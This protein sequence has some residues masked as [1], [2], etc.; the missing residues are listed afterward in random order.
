MAFSLTKYLKQTFA[1]AGPEDDHGGLIARV[2]ASAPEIEALSDEALRAAA[3]SLRDRV[4]GGMPADELMVEAFRLAREGSRRLL[5]L[6]PFDVQMDGAV[7][8]YQGHVVEMAT[9]EGKTLAAVFPAIVQALDGQG[10]HI[11]TVNDYLAGRDA[12]WMAPLYEL[13][14]LTVASI[15][16]RMTKEE[17]RLAYDADVTYVTANEAGF[18]YLRDPQ[19][20]AVEDVVHYPF[21]FAIVDEVDSILIDE[22]R[23]PLVIAG[24]VSGSSRYARSVAG[25]V[26]QLREGADY[27][28]DE[29]RRSVALTDAGI[30]RSE[31]LLG[32]ANL[33]SEEAG[34]LLAALSVALHAEALLHRDDDYVVKDSKI[35]LVDEFK[36][37]VADRRRWPDG[38]HTALE[39]KE[40]LPLTSEGKILGS[41]TIRGLMA[42]YPKLA[43]MTGTAQSEAQEL[44][45][46]YNLRVVVVDPN[47]PSIRIDQPDVVFTNQEA[48]WQAVGRRI[49]QLHTIG[50]PVLV[51]TRSVEESEQLAARLA[52]EGV[53]C[54]VLNAR[55]D[56]LEAGIIANAGALGAVTISTNM[57]GRG[58]DI[59][60][61]GE[62]E[63][64]GDAVRALGG[65]FVLGTNRHESRRIDDQLRGR[66]GRQG[67]PGETQ[68][69]VA[70]DDDLMVRYGLTDLLAGKADRTSKEPIDDPEV[71]AEIVRAQRIIEGQNF[72]ARLTLLKYDLLLEQQRK[73]VYEKRDL[74]LY[75]EDQGLLAEL[76][77]TG[78]RW[79]ELVGLYGEPHL[80][81]IERV[82]T[83][84][85]LD[86]RW[87]EHLAEMTEVREGI[88]L[89]AMSGDPYQQFNILMYERFNQLFDAVEDALVD[90]FLDAQ[91]DE[92]GID[93]EA[94]GLGAPSSTWTYMVTDNPFG[95]SMERVMRGLRDRVLRMFSAK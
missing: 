20:R 46:N 23:I 33:Y 10:V 19:A 13:F 66:A 47:R 54:N 11:L 18:D 21:R 78:E 44:R 45:E 73:I 88:H 15:H 50:R 35:H 5:G 87:T 84:A 92:H 79:A 43:G 31:G 49:A 12:R 32:V 64:N 56:E 82:M 40:G 6:P 16:Q 37:R 30:A 27:S 9:G 70:I 71:G 51:G 41:L 75:G 29:N 94:A 72:D 42:L 7:R 61:G 24:S 68:F 63:A 25:V 59:G 4:R 2:L 81:S 39:A 77:E 57:A 67:D 90:T 80:R 17:R 91:I 62:N 52:G 93:L 83:L 55:N 1:A 74:V 28:F 36:G 85:L 89:R 48:K 58:T 65:L 22:A 53:P 60:L 95:T 34:E 26:R 14:G 69:Y 86:Q 3:V 8:L 38:I 76:E